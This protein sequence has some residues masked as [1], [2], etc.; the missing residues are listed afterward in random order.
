MGPIA[1]RSPFLIFVFHRS[2]RSRAEEKVF[3][4][5]L[6]AKYVIWFMK[7]QEQSVGSRETAPLSEDVS[8]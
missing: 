5:N 2:R 1:L 4:K 8:C 7:T 3:I 6:I